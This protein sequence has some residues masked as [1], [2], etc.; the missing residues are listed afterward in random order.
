MNLLKSVPKLLKRT[1]YFK[2]AVNCILFPWTYRQLGSYGYL[3]SINKLLE[4]WVSFYNETGRCCWLV[5][6]KIDSIP[7]SSRH[8]SS[9]VK[10]RS[11]KDTEVSSYSCAT[12]T[13][14]SRP[15]TIR[16]DGKEEIQARMNTREGSISTVWT[17]ATWKSKLKAGQENCRSFPAFCLTQSLYKLR[18]LQLSQG[19]LGNMLGGQCK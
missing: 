3:V 13:Y 11:Y 15:A 9:T 2:V 16:L 14:V 18:C 6:W 8:V 4:A 12:K 10:K 5:C 1:K 19:G 17:A 7:A